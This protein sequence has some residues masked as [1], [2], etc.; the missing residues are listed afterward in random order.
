MCQHLQRNYLA[1]Y[2]NE[3]KGDS[4][5]LWKFLKTF[6]PLKTK[7]ISVKDIHGKTTDEEIASEFN[8]VCANIGGGL[9]SAFDE[10]NDDIPNVLSANPPKFDLTPGDY[11]TVFKLIQELPK[12][13][14]SGGDWLT[15]RFL[16]DAKDCVV[17][18]LTHIFNLSITTKVF[19]DDWKV[20]QVTPIFKDG[21]RSEASNYR[22]ITLLPM[23]S[24]LLERLVH[25]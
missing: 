8:N 3:C 9:A 12:G 4:G 19:P 11:D 2:V 6:W 10:V 7:S 16:Q 18:P 22:P 17:G 25:N 20:G 15:A 21:S 23:A 1:N 14:S 5:K 13:K 24:K